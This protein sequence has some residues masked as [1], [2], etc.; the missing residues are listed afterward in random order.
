MTFGLTQ[1]N[2]MNL[3]DVFTC[4]AVPVLGYQMDTEFKQN[5]GMLHW[6]TCTCAKIMVYADSDTTES[7]FS[8][9]FIYDCGD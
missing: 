8:Q 1:S 2:Y 4:F 5:V 6:Y 3:I 9:G 7:I